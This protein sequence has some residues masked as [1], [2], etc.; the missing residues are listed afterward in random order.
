[1]SLDGKAVRSSSDVYDIL[2]E[3]RVGDRVK[4]DVI[5]DGKQTL[6]LTV[7][8]GERLLGAVEE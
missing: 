6:G 5:R 4:L 1:M 2:D 8:L 3:H 7:T